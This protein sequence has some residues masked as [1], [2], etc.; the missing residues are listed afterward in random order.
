MFAL[1]LDWVPFGRPLACSVVSLGRIASRNARVA[2]RAALLR[3]LRDKVNAFNKS[4]LVLP[5]IVTLA[6]V[7]L[8]EIARVLG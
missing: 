2:R 7:A 8:P 6:F 5:A 1:G 3:K 4:S